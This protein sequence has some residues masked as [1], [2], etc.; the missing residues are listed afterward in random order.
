MSCLSALGTE[1][2]HQATHSL[3]SHIKMPLYHNQIVKELQKTSRRR[4][5][6]SCQFDRGRVRRPPDGSRG[7]R[8]LSNF[9]LP[10]A[11]CTWRITKYIDPARCCQRA[12]GR[13][14]KIISGSRGERPLRGRCFPCPHLNYI[15]L[16]PSGKPPIG[17]PWTQMP[18]RSPDGSSGIAQPRT[19][20]V[21]GYCRVCDV[22]G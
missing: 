12:Y 11:C 1:P 18:R 4:G 2:M 22:G 7:T 6:F 10:G 20:R 13:I 8:P 16:S 15:G 3:G 19:P 21:F 9:T 17:R 5:V 14:P